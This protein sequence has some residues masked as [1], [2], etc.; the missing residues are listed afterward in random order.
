[1]ARASKKSVTIKGLDELTRKLKAL[2]EHVEEASRRAVKAE[3]HETADDMRAGAPFET[4]ELRES[5][6]AEFDPKT[7]TGRAVATARHAAFVENGT[8]DTPAQPFAEPAA[9]RARQR[10]PGRVKQEITEE[11]RKVTR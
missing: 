8:S 10:F 1:M 11:L 7:I 4:G 2:P 3:T 5:I 9:A 6:Q